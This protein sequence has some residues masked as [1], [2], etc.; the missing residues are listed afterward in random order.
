MLQAPTEVPLQAHTF[1]SASILQ[2]YFVKGDTYVHA[3][4]HG[5]SSTIV[6]NPN[7]ERPIPPLTLQQVRAR[8]R[9]SVRP[10]R[11][12]LAIKMR[13]SRMD[14]GAPVMPEDTMECVSAVPVRT[15]WSVFQLYP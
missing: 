14:V 2:R 9:M 5:A 11:A 6:K 10:V 15:P 3:E 7:P 13:P 12:H 4:L 8:V 1:V